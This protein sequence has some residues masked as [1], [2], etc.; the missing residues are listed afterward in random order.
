MFEIEFI[1]TGDAAGVPVWGCDCPACR[2]ASADPARRR[3]SACVAVHT[4][5]GVTLIDA[6]VGDLARRFAFGQI[7]RILLTHFHMDHVQGLFP[8]RWC[9]R[10]PRIPVHRPDDPIGADDLYKHPGVLDFRP[11]LAPFVEHD[12]GDLH[13]TPLPLRHSRPTQG[14]VL[15]HQRHRLAYLT[16]TAGLPETTLRHLQRHPVAALV[17]DCHVPPQP[18]PP[19][20]HNDLTTALALWRASGAPRLWLTHVGHHLDDWLRQPGNALPEGVRVAADGLRL[21]GDGQVRTTHRPSRHADA[22]RSP[23]EARLVT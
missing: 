23:P 22:T 9:E 11:P 8:L 17:L 18:R 16:D 13:I 1:G 12:L 21:A 10:T 20:N 15:R 7:R 19:R 14:Y 5:T 6:G 4:E 2:R 3:E